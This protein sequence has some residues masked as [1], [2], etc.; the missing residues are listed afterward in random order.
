MNSLQFDLTLCKAQELSHKYL[1]PGH[2]V[3]TPW[4]R[5][6]GKSW[7]MRLMWYLAVYEWDGRKRPGAPLPGIRIVLV[8]PTLEQAR[9]VHT[10]L[11]IA[12]LDG[13]WI[14][15]GGQLNK[16]NWRVS[17]PGGSWIQII[18]AERANNA[19]GIRCDFVC[20]DECDDIDPDIIDS[21]VKPWFSEPHSLRMLLVAGTPRRGRKGTLY[22]YWKVVPAK[23]PGKAHAFHATAYDAPR[24]VDQDYLEEVRLTTPE[25][26][27]K[28]EWLCDIDSA[29]GLVYSIFSDTFH[30]R[31]PDPDVVWD[32]VVFGAD[33]GYED[34]GVIL[35]A[36]ILGRGRDRT[37]W[38]LDEVVAVR[39]DPNWW[40][41]QVKERVGW[42][43]E[44][45]W[46]PDSARP[47]IGAAWKAAGAR[48][49][50]VEKFAGSV[51]AGVNEIRRLLAINHFRRG[52]Q[53]VAT[54]RF[55][56]HPR[57]TFT[58]NEFGSYRHKRDSKN[59][60]QMT[61]EI[62]DRWNHAMDALR[63]LVT[64]KLGYTSLPSA[65][66]GAHGEA[67]Q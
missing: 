48:V 47:D 59:P 7:F 15:L 56:I 67:R 30:V 45:E 20:V 61:D 22:R 39:K 1:K 55:Y 10:D 3:C 13:S 6:I 33:H 64:G 53:D 65:K 4:G 44:A 17:F 50:Q 38:V 18:T 52:D 28:R 60:E 21:V 62:E 46:Y 25:P 14:F 49:K 5:G 36:G 27:F 63:Y 34:P 58:I 43:P 26:I 41:A 23:L 66:G 8:M 16:S 42:Y 29:E 32:E 57:C 11:L 31:E 19:R 37:V 35:C 2:T 40:E 54:S 24:L 12:E 51:E 9:K